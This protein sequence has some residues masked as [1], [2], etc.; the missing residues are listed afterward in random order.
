MALIGSLY[1]LYRFRLI[2]LRLP[3]FVIGELRRRR[4]IGTEYPP[5]VPYHVP[6]L[7]VL[8]PYYLPFSGLSLGDYRVGYPVELPY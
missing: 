1:L 2:L 3:K 4:P 8:P 5:Y 6:Y 7:G